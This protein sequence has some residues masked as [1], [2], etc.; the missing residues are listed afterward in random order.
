MKFSP[1]N[2]HLLVEKIEEPEVDP[3]PAVLLPADYKPKAE[4]HSYVRIK[5]V[6]PDCTLIISPGDI[7]LVETHMLNKIE[8]QEKISYLVLE[9]YVL[10]V[11]R[12]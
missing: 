9:N 6:S 11:L 7:A 10:G 8:V 12:K 2:R 3:R 1:R 5:D 4:E